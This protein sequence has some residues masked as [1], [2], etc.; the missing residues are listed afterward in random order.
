MTEA[1]PYAN[2]SLTDRLQMLAFDAELAYL[3]RSLIETTWSACT[4]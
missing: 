1:D 4:R 2:W 3:P